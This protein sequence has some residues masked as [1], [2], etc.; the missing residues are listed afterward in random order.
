[1]ALRRVPDFASRPPIVRPFRFVYF[2]AVADQAKHAAYHGQLVIAEVLLHRLMYAKAR[3]IRAINLHLHDEQQAHA[4][5][6]LRSSQL[7]ADSAERMRWIE[8]NGRRRTRPLNREQLTQALIEQHGVSLLR[9]I[10][11]ATCESHAL[12][13]ED[14]AWLEMRA[15]LP[16]LQ[17]PLNGSE[18][19][20]LVRAIEAVHAVPANTTAG[21]ADNSAIALRAAAQLGL[22]HP[23]YAPSPFRVGALSAA[24]LA[25]HHDYLSRRA[26]FASAAELRLRFS[27]ARPRVKMDAKLARQRTEHAALLASSALAA[28]SRGGAMRVLEGAP[29]GALD[30]PRGH[31][32]ASARAATR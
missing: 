9:A 8:R 19:R 14:Q 30:Y 18:Y 4:L 31:A 21:C 25:G 22:L 28:A 5:Q 6:R 26:A 27:H 12:C 1:M 2:V 17:R 20:R 13:G 15:R 16:I 3:G 7:A 32:S 11:M 24:Y 10:G 23:D 29:R